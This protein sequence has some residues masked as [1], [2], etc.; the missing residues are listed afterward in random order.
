VGT[1][2][3]VLLVTEKNES[4]SCVEEPARSGRHRSLGRLD[5][6]RPARRLVS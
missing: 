3:S 5:A 1:E 6:V 4:A 2:A